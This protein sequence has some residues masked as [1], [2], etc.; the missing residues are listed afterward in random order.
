MKTRGGHEVQNTRWTNSGGIREQMHEAQ[1]QCWVNN[2]AHYMQNETIRTSNENKRNWE[3]ARA[4]SKT[5]VM[6]RNS[7]SRFRDAGTMFYWPMM[8]VQVVP[9]EESRWMKGTVKP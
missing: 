1:R 6:T 9:I 5:E 3:R 8:V 4:V 2:V 7:S